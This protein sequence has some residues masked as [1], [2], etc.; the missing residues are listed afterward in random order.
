MQN[1]TSNKNLQK[2]LLRLQEV[3]K[4][5]TKVKIMFFFNTLHLENGS[6]VH[7]LPTIFVTPH[8]VNTRNDILCKSK[9]TIQCIFVKVD[10]VQFGVIKILEKVYYGKKL[11]TVVK[12]LEILMS[13]G[14]AANYK[15]DGLPFHYKA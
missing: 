9:N 3:R 4:V 7:N 15:R 11:F 1:T 8:I 13:L 5:T 2:K 12:T 10:L 14:T 6:F